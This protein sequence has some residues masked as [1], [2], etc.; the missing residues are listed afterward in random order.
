MLVCFLD[1][2]FLEGREVRGVFCL[3][4]LLV[5]EG[6][7]CVILDKEFLYFRDRNLRGLKFCC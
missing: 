2:K 5:R 1:G 7:E 6:Y 4:I 3:D